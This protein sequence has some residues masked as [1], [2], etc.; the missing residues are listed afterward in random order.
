MTGWSRRCRGVIPHVKWAILNEL[1]NCKFL[2]VFHN[3]SGNYVDLWECGVPVMGAMS[4]RVLW[5]S[6]AGRFMLCDDALEEVEM[7]K[8]AGLSDVFISV[9]PQSIITRNAVVNVLF[10]FLH[11]EAEE[12]ARYNSVLEPDSSKIVLECILYRVLRRHYD[13][14]T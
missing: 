13:T 5:A 10:R 2:V 6:Q 11:A 7:E 1:S 3:G 14:T 12:V 4:K 9:G 8:L